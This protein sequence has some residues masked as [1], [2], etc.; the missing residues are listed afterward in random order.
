MDPR[1]YIWADLEDEFRKVFL[2]MHV[3]DGGVASTWENKIIEILNILTRRYGPLVLNTPIKSYLSMNITRHDSGAFTFSMDNNI[4]KILEATNMGS[5]P[6][7]SQPARLD[8]F[9]INHNSPPFSNDGIYKTIVGK[10]IHPTKI[11]FDIKLSVANVA[12]FTKSPS[13]HNSKQLMDVLQYL[14]GTPDL[15]PTY[16][17]TNGPIYLAECDAAHAVYEGGEDHFGSRYMVGD[18]YN[19]PFDTDSRRQLTCISTSPAGGEFLVLSE[20]CQKIIIY[21]NFAAE[22]FFPQRQPTNLYTDCDPAI[23]MATSVELNPKT[24]IYTAKEGFIR[25]CVD[26]GIVK[27]HHIEGKGNPTDLLAKPTTGTDFKNKR[28]I[29][30]NPEFSRYL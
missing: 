11:R 15:G 13:E 3:D 10:L 30:A 16:F 18:R 26:R 28:N 2:S 22:C 8:A 17:T 27:L 4:N 6:S 7:I 24:K 29:K 9:R 1:K 14:K 23:T 20:T 12:R 19:A 25:Q 5:V 21:R